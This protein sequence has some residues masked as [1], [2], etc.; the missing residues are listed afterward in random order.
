MA[1]GRSTKLTGKVQEEI[2]KAIRA[3]S[4]FEIACRW[5]GI[6]PATG[7][8]WLA[9]GEGKEPKGRRKSK[10]YAE[11]A[12]AIR[13]VEAELEMALIIEW[14]KHLPTNAA[15]AAEMLKRRFP[16]R[17]SAPDK[18]ELGGMDGK[19]IEVI[20]TPSDP[21][22]PKRIARLLSAFVEAGI[23]PEESLARFQSAQ[24]NK[25]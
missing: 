21:Y 15:A 13:K 17:W 4:F 8:E 20:E 11:F 14:R 5:A 25:S 3:G 23:L 10:E 18:L 1:A 7:W 16:K 6:H 12:E 9:R 19:P 24:Q 2:V 22:D